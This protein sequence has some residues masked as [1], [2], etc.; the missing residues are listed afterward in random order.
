MLG[1]KNLP[2]ALKIGNKGEDIAANYLQKNGLKIIN[3]NI[4]NRYGEIDI[5][6]KQNNMLIFVEVRTRKKDSLVSAVA[7]I[8]YQKQQKW[9]KASQ[10]YIQQ[11]NW[12]GD[13]RFD[14]VAITYQNNDYQIEWLINVL[15]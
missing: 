15:D 8:N 1:N 9:Q 6:A 14:V 4:K 11:N 7:S 2:F 5:I 3:R 12:N 13:C 10:F